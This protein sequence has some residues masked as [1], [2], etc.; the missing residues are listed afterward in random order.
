MT[1][2][3]FIEKLSCGSCKL[4]ASGQV[5]VT[6]HHS[7]TLMAEWQCAGCGENII[8]TINDESRA[9][10]SEMIGVQDLSETQSQAS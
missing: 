3:E 8:Y 6:T 9:T 2:E 1:D 4:K 5:T 7:G 10:P